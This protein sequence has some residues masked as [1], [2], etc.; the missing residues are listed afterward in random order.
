[1]IPSFN[2]RKK[3]EPIHF[4]LNDYYTSIVNTTAARFYSS[5][6]SWCQCYEAFTCPFYKIL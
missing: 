1:M 2:L 4:Q 6:V 5:K 3:C